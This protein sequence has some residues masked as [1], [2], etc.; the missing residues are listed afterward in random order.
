[1]NEIQAVLINTTVE[2]LF[3]SPQTFD[4]ERLTGLGA[5]LVQ[6]LGARPSDAAL[7]LRDALYNYDLTVSIFRGQGFVK[8]GP[9]K[10]EMSVQDIRNQADLELVKTVFLKASSTLKASDKMTTFV[11]ANFHLNLITGDRNKYFSAYFPILDGHPV[12]GGVIYRQSPSFLPD[13]RVQLERSNV[14]P[15]ALFFSWTGGVR[16]L[17]TAEVYESLQKEITSSMTLFKLL[18][19]PTKK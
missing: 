10:I 9:E 13:I 16:G 18:V 3:G 12:Q 15:G 1:V 19:P 11:Q 2:T 4:R 17:F 5:K 6:A 8:V 7:N 14:I